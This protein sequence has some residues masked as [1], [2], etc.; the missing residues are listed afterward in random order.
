MGF[1]QNLVRRINRNIILRNVVLALCAFI[2]FIVL[3]I[4][5]LN[6]FTRHG[7]ERLVPDFSG[8]TVEEALRAGRGSKLRI[9]VNDSLYVPA[10]EGGIILEQN[11]GP[12]DEVKS[13]RRIF[14]TVNSYRQ[15]KVVIP[16]VTGYSLRQAKTNLDLA[17]LEIE[18]LIY[19]PDLATNNVLEERFGDKIIRPDNKLEAEVG[20]GITLLVGRGDDAVLQVV[21]RVVGFSLREA[22][23]RLWEIGFNL[24][25]V[26]VDE[27]ITPLNERDAKVYSQSPAPGSRMEYGTPVNISLTLDE[28]KVEKGVAEAAR[29]ARAA[30]EAWAREQE[31]NRSEG[32]NR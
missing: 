12:G 23:S 29:A 21:P 11:P 32:E 24:G 19:R 25:K 5:S 15:K 1:L 17:G 13:G 10:Y 8:M 6:L 9:E 3:A 20:S 14:V 27:G 30:A 16:Y 22:K 28:P 4:L 31:E 26:T 7:Q 18:K 2:V